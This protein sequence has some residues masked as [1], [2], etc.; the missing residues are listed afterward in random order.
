MDENDGK[1]NLIGSVKKGKSPDAPFVGEVF[2]CDIEANQKA[3]KACPVG[4][5]KLGN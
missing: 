3:A 1:A 4:I 5:I 2:D